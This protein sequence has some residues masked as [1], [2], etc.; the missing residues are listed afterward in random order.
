MEQFKEAWGDSNGDFSY[1]LKILL[2]LPGKF[3]TTLSVLSEHKT[4]SLGPWRWQFHLNSL[5]NCPKKIHVLVLEKNSLL[6][7]CTVLFPISFHFSSIAQ[8]RLSLLKSTLLH[9]G[10][11]TWSEHRFWEC[12]G[13]NSYIQIAFLREISVMSLRRKDMVRGS[14]P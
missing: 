13:Q 9:L 12:H 6:S 11:D 7:L 3:L 5:P 8:G 2:H 14:L 10:C 1:F 4:W